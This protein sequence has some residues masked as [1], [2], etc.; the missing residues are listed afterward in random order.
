MGSQEVRDRVKCMESQ[1]AD[2]ETRN[3]MIVYNDKDG[4]RRRAM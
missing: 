3:M 1:H 4:K 2:K